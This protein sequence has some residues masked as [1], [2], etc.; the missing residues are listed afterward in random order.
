M[1]GM[2]LPCNFFRRIRCKFIIFEIKKPEAN[3]LERMFTELLREVIRKSKTDI[4][5]ES[6]N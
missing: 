4:G 5:C 1:C 6:P 2:Y 3:Y